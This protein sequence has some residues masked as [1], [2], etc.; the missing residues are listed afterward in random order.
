MTSIISMDYNYVDYHLNASNMDNS[1]ELH[2]SI[3]SLIKII[4]N[5]TFVSET[6][7]SI[8]NKCSYLLFIKNIIVNNTICQEYNNFIIFLKKKRKETINNSNRLHDYIVNKLSKQDLFIDEYG[9]KCI[10]PRPE[11]ERSSY[12]DI[13]IIET[14]ICILL[15]QIK[16][17]LRNQFLYREY[18][19]L[20]IINEYS[21]VK[22]Q[23]IKLEL[24]WYNINIKPI[25]ETGI[26]IILE[27]LQLR[28]FELTKEINKML[29]YL[30]NMNYNDA[31]KFYES[32][33][34]NINIYRFRIIY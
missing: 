24:T 21:D 16:E 2:I 29:N 20:N 33:M 19:L 4:N 15:L 32:Y 27:T 9:N 18:Y 7:S 17:S 28:Y 1:I 13:N 12:Y 22:H 8:I 31:N 5:N 30:K 6:N 23:I 3:N 14:E 10:L 26:V 25:Y 11:L 34:Y